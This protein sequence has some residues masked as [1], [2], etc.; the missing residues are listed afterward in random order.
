MVK[1]VYVDKADVVSTLRSRGLDTRA[2]WVERELPACID[3]QK[4][5]A[6]LETLAID[7]AIL[8][9]CAGGVGHSHQ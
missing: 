9:P 7:P 4:N 2:D 3:I 1:A 5:S 6:L 8:S